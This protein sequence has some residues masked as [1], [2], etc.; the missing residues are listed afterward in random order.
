LYEA[1]EVEWWWAQRSRSTDASVQLFWYDDAGRPA[2]A[3]IATQL[4][5][6]VQLDPLVMP[7]ASPEWIAHV[8]ER[9]LAYANESGIESVTFEVDSADDVLRSVLVTRG[10]AIEADGGL[11]EAWLSPEA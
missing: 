6:R 1:A 9:R 8:M 2:A 5:D 4:G 7:D 10:F 11:V 3:V